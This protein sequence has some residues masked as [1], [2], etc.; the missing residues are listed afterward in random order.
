MGDTDRIYLNA[1]KQKVSELEAKL[2]EARELLQG[3][4]NDRGFYYL[5]NE[6]QDL[7]EELRLND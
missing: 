5:T 6:M 2:A 7:L 3:V 1:W 4:Y